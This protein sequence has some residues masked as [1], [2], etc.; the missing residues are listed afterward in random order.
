MKMIRIGRRRR[1][2]EKERGMSVN[3]PLELLI[4]YFT[5]TLEYDKYMRVDEHISSCE[6]CQK[7]LHHL[8]EV[9]ANIIL[10]EIEK[11]KAAETGPSYEHT[12]DTECV[13]AHE[14]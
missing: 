6:S 4:S 7:I 1:D 3:D 8:R 13:H 14:R 10:H 11:A 5:G 2:G 12:R 9:N